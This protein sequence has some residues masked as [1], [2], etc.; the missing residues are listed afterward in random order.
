M[1]EPT[2]PGCVIKVR[3]IGVFWMLDGGVPDGKILTVPAGDVRYAGMRDLR[4]VHEH[5][6]DEIAH[7]FDIY[8]NLEPGKGT[9]V[10]GWQDRRV[11]DRTIERAAA[12]RAREVAGNA[13]T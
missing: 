3:S 1:A 6:L 8:K 9:D 10:R 5:V 4:D 7:F 11:A 2:F 12:E 13:P